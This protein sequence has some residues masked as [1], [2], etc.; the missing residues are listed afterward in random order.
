MKHI[1]QPKLLTIFT[2]ILLNGSVF[3]HE[4]ETDKEAKST[5]FTGLETSAG[6]TV[7]AFHKALETG[8]AQTARGLLADDVLILEGKGVER[9]A[10]EY[11]SHHMLSDMKYLKAMTIESIEHHVTQFDVVA[12]SISRSSVKGTYKDKNIDRIGNETIALK[13]HDDKWKITH[14][15]WSN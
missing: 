3:S 15:H 12:I 14:I 11:A 5:M 4:N 13:K 9:S 10:Q 2:L 7:L 6:K 1:I 8:D